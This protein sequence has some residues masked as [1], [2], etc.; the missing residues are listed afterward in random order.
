MFHQVSAIVAILVRMFRVVTVFVNVSRH[1][2]T[3]FVF[4]NIVAHCV[5]FSCAVFQHVSAI[6]G[7]FGRGR[8]QPKKTNEFFGAR[9]TQSRGSRYPGKWGLSWASGA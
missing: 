7:V 3:P 8:R 4:L 6:V 5:V 9:A 2:R 1:F